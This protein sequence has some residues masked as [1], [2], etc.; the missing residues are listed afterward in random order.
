MAGD[1]A[2][3]GEAGSPASPLFPERLRGVLA[4]FWACSAAANATYVNAG[5]GAAGPSSLDLLRLSVE[6]EDEVAAA[7][8]D[9]SMRSC[10][11]AAFGNSGLREKSKLRLVVL[12]GELGG[13]KLAGG[14]GTAATA[15]LPDCCGG[16]AARG[17]LLHGPGL[18]EVLP[19]LLMLR[20]HPPGVAVE[21]VE[22]AMAELEAVPKLRGV[23]GTTPGAGARC[24]D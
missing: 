6:E 22:V 17:A 9:A 14:S 7:G 20:P 5:A 11:C 2:L 23:A 18:Q 19:V 21:E 15:G 13:I 10:A 4:P 12:A 3:A 24:G 8:N 1:A 16:E